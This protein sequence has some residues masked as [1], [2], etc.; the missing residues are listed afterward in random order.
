MHLLMFDHVYYVDQNVTN[1]A[2]ITYF[3]CFQ[4][5]Y[6]TNVA[7]VLHSIPVAIFLVMPFFLHFLDGGICSS[8]LAFYDFMKGGVQAD[9]FHLDRNGCLLLVFYLMFCSISF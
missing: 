7:I 5:Y 3:I 4:I 1:H 2:D 9:K 8:F 6:S